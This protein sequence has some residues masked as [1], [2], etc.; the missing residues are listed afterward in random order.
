MAPQASWDP[1][2]QLPHKGLKVQASTP[3]HKTDRRHAIT[4]TPSARSASVSS[5][6]GVNGGHGLWPL[7]EAGKDTDLP[8]WARAADEAQDSAQAAGDAVPKH[9][10]AEGDD[11]DEPVSQRTAAL[12]IAHRRASGASEAP[13]SHGGY[14]SEE[15]LDEYPS[16]IPPPKPRSGAE[17]GLG[18][19]LF[20]Q[21]SVKANSNPTNAAASRRDSLLSNPGGVSRRNSGMSIASGMGGSRRNMFSRQGSVNFE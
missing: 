20:A 5:P 11:A 16:E 8:E 14:D 15:C 6:G 9:G 1:T 4:W 7:A 3:G 13:S 19:T 2:A 21:S 17:L 10:D 12:H 18:A